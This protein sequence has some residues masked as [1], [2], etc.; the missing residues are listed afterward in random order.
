MNGR[1]P[2]SE[3]KSAQREQPGIAVATSYGLLQF[4]L[5]LL[6]PPLT[7]MIPGFFAETMGM[8]LAVVGTISGLI[9]MVHHIGGGLGAFIGGVMFETWGGYDE[10][11][12][13]MF[14]LA[15]VGM[16]FTIVLRERPLAP[17]TVTV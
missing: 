12:M 13:L 7:S 10:A 4:P 2:L 8:P 9:T 16:A 17:A 5:G 1:R 14:A 15:V 6:I 3:G 11:F